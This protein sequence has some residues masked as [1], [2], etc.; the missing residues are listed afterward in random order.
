M[1]KCQTDIN[2]LFN[3][4]SWIYSSLQSIQSKN[5]V[6]NFIIDLQI[7]DGIDKSLKM[8]CNNRV[9][10][11]YSKNNWSSSKLK[12]IDIKFLVV[13][14]RVQ[15]GQV[16]IEYISTNSMIADSFTKSLPPKVFYE[17]V[18]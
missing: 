14:K 6:H 2:S 12:H 15:S 10:E 16:L 13:N 5:L 3:H 11:L 4:E 7:V 1:E 18:A 9:V 17:D 8:N